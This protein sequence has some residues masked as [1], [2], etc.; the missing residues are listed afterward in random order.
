MVSGIVKTAFSGNF[1][2]NHIQH[3]EKI[4]K[5]FV[6][7][8]ILLNGALYGADEINLLDGSRSWQRSYGLESAVL[9][10]GVLTV[11][12]NAKNGHTLPFKTDYAAA[13]Y[14]Y[15][16]MQIQAEQDFDG[17]IAIFFATEQT[18]ELADRMAV[19]MP[20]K[21]KSGEPRILNFNMARNSRYQGKITRLRLDAAGEPGA[22]LKISRFQIAGKPYEGT[23]VKAPAL[24]LNQE[25]SMLKSQVSVTEL[26]GATGHVTVDGDAISVEKTNAQ[27]QLLIQVP[28]AAPVKKGQDYWLEC[29]YTTADA[30]L[31]SILML[32]GM[33]PGEEPPGKLAK[34][35]FGGFWVWGTYT[36][37]RNTPTGRYDKRYGT[38][39]AS[40]DAEEAIANLVV[41]GNPFSITIRNIRIH[42]AP[43]PEVPAYKQEE[44]QPRYTQQEV[45]RILE[46]RPEISAKLGAING[47]KALLVNGDSRAGF[48]L[49]KG[50][51][52]RH[53]RFRGQD[54]ANFGELGIQKQVVSVTTGK[55]SPTDESGFWAGLGQYEFGQ[56]DRDIYDAL[57]KNPYADIVLGF[58]IRPCPF[59][60]RLRPVTELAVNH[61]GERVYGPGLYGVFT[62]DF[63]IVDK[64]GSDKYW[65][66]SWS[67]EI[68]RRDCID[69]LKAA[70][71]HIRKQPYGKVVIG[72]TFS[73]GD[74]GQF[75]SSFYDQSEAARN[76][77][78]KFLRGQY[79]SIDALNR[80]W[81]S[82]Y[83]TFEEI[84]PPKERV[85]NW[86]VTHRPVN[87]E[88][89]FASSR[90]T[91]TFG[92]R[93]ALAAG[94][95]EGMEKDVFAFAY[96]YPAGN[97]FADLKHADGLCFQ[98]GYFQ[99]R[100][101]IPTINFPRTLHHRKDLAYMAEFDTRGL[102]DPF[103]NLFYADGTGRAEN[104][105]EWNQAHRKLVG[106]ILANGYLYWYYDMNQYY[107]APAYRKEIKEVQHTVEKLFSRPKTPFKPDVCV[108]MGDR[109][110]EFTN[111]WMMLTAHINYN[112]QLQ[113]YAVS[114]V[115][116]DKVYLSEIKKY[117]ELK[118][119]KVLI[120]FQ[121]AYFS[122]DDREFINREL[123]KDGRTIIWVYNPGFISDR[124]MD[125]REFSEFIG[126]KIRH[127]GKP[128]KPLALYR[129]G[130]P[131]M[132]G[133]PAMCNGLNYLSVIF[134]AWPG[135]DT[136]RIEDDGVTPL[137]DFAGGGG[138]AGALKRFENWTGIYLAN[139]HSL[140]GRLL[141]NIAKAAGCY[142]AGDYGQELS[143]DGDFA[144]VHG[145]RRDDAYT[146]A[147]PPG[148][149]KIYEAFSGALLGENIAAYTFA[150]E[151]WQTY[152]FLFE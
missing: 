24:T 113:E 146:L 137:A 62:S 96:G 121:N 71:S 112:P 31:N 78:I 117:P 63:S 58:H 2:Q 28:L 86:S 145:I 99:R 147:L 89:D 37:V 46:Q 142:V 43:W 36:S 33:L 90:R 127:D 60:S 7:L 75:G 6:L 53:G 26:E 67:S 139:P 57:Q 150:V 4:M 88:S 135:W 102:P 116:M 123:K 97:Y 68:F 120:F 143:L 74:D 115:P 132:E 73:G 134:P 12:T 34:N 114:G 111:H 25:K 27:G 85:E 50:M 16:Q 8:A 56:M 5:Y 9:Q 126:M 144:S 130:A 131:F 17:R 106:N 149:N 29:E 20:C 19:S 83:R 119:Y 11:K 23:P 22:V 148:K 104:Q 152:W 35:E 52:K 79:G 54:Y 66:P 77:F 80:V 59:W 42:S 51:D 70:G 92:F 13:E 40:A 15:F 93:D 124:G 125:E 136:F 41:W 138:V 108:V 118:N 109:E 87:L 76:Q 101:G 105:S 84:Q 64:E 140:H 14:P 45:L 30:A 21:L 141:R 65:L 72:A 107:N 47:R 133:V 91:A 122:D 81:K 61:K 3:K 151:P 1:Q 10:N 39:T 110:S 95:K 82:S 103:F 128:G 38:F 44:F 49:Y 100:A 98:P 18:S 48:P 32:R 94:F 55:T 69:M 129:K